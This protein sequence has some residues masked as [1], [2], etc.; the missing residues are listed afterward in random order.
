MKRWEIFRDVYLIYGEMTE[1]ATH[2][3]DPISY[4]ESNRVSYL[5]HYDRETNDGQFVWYSVGTNT[6]WVYNYD[7]DEPLTPEIISM[8]ERTY[9]RNPDPSLSPSMKVDIDN[10]SR[11][12]LSLIYEKSK[13]VVAD[14]NG[15]SLY[16]VDPS[17][18]LQLRMSM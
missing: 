5:D 8:I 6:L 1:G 10:I 17:D 13:Y 9:E 3:I 4:A 11:P 14:D 7:F 2:I 15:M 16:G 12:L 18:V